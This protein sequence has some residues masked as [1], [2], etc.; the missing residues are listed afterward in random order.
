[1]TVPLFNP[2]P[3]ETH[4]KILLRLTPDDF[5]LLVKG[6]PLGDERV[7]KLSPLTLSLPRATYRFY[8]V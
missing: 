4:L 5:N 6:R 7:K 8:S 1:M 2:F 3:P